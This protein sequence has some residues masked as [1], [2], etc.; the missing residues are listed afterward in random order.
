M[1]LTLIKLN[2]PVT[3][4]AMN[5]HLNQKLFATKNEKN[6][7]KSIK[8]SMVFVNYKKFCTHQFIALFRCV[9]ALQ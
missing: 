1:L 8:K 2:R 6:S 9:I 3:A 4:G 5:A 7:I